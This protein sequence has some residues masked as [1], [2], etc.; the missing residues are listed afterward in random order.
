[1]RKFEANVVQYFLYPSITKQRPESRC[2]Q[3]AINLNL[4]N[5]A[6]LKQHVFACHW[7]VLL[8]F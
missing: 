3:K 2:H 4:L 1:V 5:L 7:V 8:N 6:F